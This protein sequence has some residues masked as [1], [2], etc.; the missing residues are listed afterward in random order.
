MK[1]NI[2]SQCANCQFDMFNS[3]SSDVAKA[4]IAVYLYDLSLKGYG[5][6]RIQKTFDV[7]KNYMSGE[8][9][10]FLGKTL[11]SDDMIRHQALSTRILV[12]PVDRTGPAQTPAPRCGHGSRKIREYQMSEPGDLIRQSDR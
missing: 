6:K 8:T 11:R 9:L 5:K 4:V 7:F 2:K 10:N 1:S 12:H 3:I